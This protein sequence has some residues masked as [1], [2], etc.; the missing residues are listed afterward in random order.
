MVITIIV[1]FTLIQ[2]FSHLVFTDHYFNRFSHTRE[3][4]VHDLNSIYYT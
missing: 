1:Y 2:S 3:V 4:Q